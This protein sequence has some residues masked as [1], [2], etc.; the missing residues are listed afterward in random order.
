M[1]NYKDQVV[2]KLRH[3]ALRAGTQGIHYLEE[4]VARATKALEQ[5]QDK[6]AQYEE[7]SEERARVKEES[8]SN[9]RAE[10]RATAE[11]ILQEAH[12][13][14][15]RIKQARPARHPMTVTVEASPE[16][17]KSRT[18]GRK[19]TTTATAPKRAT[20]RPGGFKAKRGQK[21]SHDH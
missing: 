16:P 21:H 17:I 1:V 12:A 6:L 14:E 3:V 19:T 18:Q 8:S 10:T 7:T 2:G 4:G 11:F 13:V 20:A 5:L 9:L 15:E